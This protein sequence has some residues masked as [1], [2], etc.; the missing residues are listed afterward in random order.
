MTS[1]FADVDVK[2]QRGIEGVDF[3]APGELVL[4]NLNIDWSIVESSEISHWKLAHYSAVESWLTDY[5]PKPDAPNLE[6][7]RGYLE[8][9]HHLCEVEDWER[10]SKILTIR[11]DKLTNQDLLIQLRTWGYYQ[12]QL[13]LYSR[14]LGKLDSHWDSACL[15]ALGIIYCS[16]GEYQQ[17]IDNYQQSLTVARVIGDLSGEGIALDG[18]GAVYFSQGDYARAIDYYHQSL[19]IAREI[20]ERPRQFMTLDSLGNVYSAK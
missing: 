4:A 8:T 11:L 15:N 10:A 19:V 12:E 14:L 13:T 9:F 3:T 18:L 17:A 20:G 1:D 16:I 7:V 6:K 2:T 5:K